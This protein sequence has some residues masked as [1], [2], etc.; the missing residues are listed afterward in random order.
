MIKAALF[1]A[2][3]LLLL[4][5]G[6]VRLAALAGL[7]RRM[8]WTFAA[9]VVAGLGLIGCRRPPGSSASGRW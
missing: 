7:G 4:R 3:G 1:A 2:A 9:I 5:L 8:P 6:S